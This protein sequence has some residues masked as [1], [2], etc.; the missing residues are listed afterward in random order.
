MPDR[1]SCRSARSSS[2]R[3]IAGHDAVCGFVRDIISARIGESTA[4]SGASCRRSGRPHSGGRGCYA[5]IKQAA[6][7]PSVV[8]TANLHGNRIASERTPW[9]D[10]CHTIFN[11]QEIRPSIKVGTCVSTVL[12]RKGPR[13]FPANCFSAI[14]WGQAE[15][16]GDAFDHLYSAIVAFDEAD[17]FRDSRSPSSRPGLPIHRHLSR[18]GTRFRSK[19]AAI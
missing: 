14:F 12:K 9:G 5:S 11:T 10:S 15:K 17:E 7:H 2:T 16:K 8:S 6:L 18:C 1:R 19:R 4:R 13:N 3:F